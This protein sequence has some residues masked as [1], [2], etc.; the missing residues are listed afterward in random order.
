MNL[1][2]FIYLL[3]IGIILARFSRI[4]GSIIIKFFNKFLTKNKILIN[5]NSMITHF[6][7]D[8]RK[9]LRKFFCK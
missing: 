4:I 5:S 1:I 9:S 8:L 3:F 6:K 7:S 2:G